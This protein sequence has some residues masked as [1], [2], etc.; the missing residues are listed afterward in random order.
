MLYERRPARRG[1]I[2]DDVIEPRPPRPRPALQVVVRAERDH[3]AAPLHRRKALRRLPRA[4]GPRRRRHHTRGHRRVHALRPLGEARRE[5]GPRLHGGDEVFRLLARR[6]GPGRSRGH[7]R[8]A[9]DPLPDAQAG[10]R[11]GG[12]R[13]G[14]RQA[15]RPF[16]RG[17]QRPHQDGLREQGALLLPVPRVPAPRPRERRRGGRRRLRGED[18]GRLLGGLGLRGADDREEALPMARGRG[19][20]RRR[21]KGRSRHQ[22]EGEAPDRAADAGD[23]PGWSWRRRS[24][25]GTENGGSETAPSSS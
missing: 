23:G 22:E 17:R 8:R 11:P 24:A 5:H 13:P 2:R 15:V 7:R 25:R 6:G 3:G 21:R 9:R 1:A 20:R 16:L 4:R 18:L 12:Y 19:D 10:G 14:A